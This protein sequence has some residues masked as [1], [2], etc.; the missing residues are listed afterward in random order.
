M[1]ID[2]I[3]GL[4]KQAV[5]IAHCVRHALRAIHGAAVKSLK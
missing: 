2:N 3:K 4:T 5:L 1:V